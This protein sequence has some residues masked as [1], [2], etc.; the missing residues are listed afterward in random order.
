MSEEYPEYNFDLTQLSQEGC[1]FNQRDVALF[2]L[3]NARAQFFARLPNCPGFIRLY[4]LAEVYLSWANSNACSFSG[5]WGDLTHPQHLQKIA[6]KNHEYPRH[7]PSQPTERKKI[8]RSEDCRGKKTS[9]WNAMKHGLSR[10][11][12]RHD[13]TTKMPGSAVPCLS[14]ETLRILPS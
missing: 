9:S 8:H 7:D 12:I 14:R 10:E 6:A 1:R 13:V 11:L 2:D 4:P 3:H 5:F